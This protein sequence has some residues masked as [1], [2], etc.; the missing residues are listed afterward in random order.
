MS[1]S[2]SKIEFASQEPDEFSAIMLDDGVKPLQVEARVSTRERLRRGEMDLLAER[3]R[4]AEG[5]DSRFKLEP[6]QLLNPADPVEWKRDG[7]QEGV[8]R[9]LR[10]G[11]YSADARLDLLNR[12]LAESVDEVPSFIKQCRRLGLR[13]V[14]IN[15]GRGQYPDSPQNILKSCLV[16][17]LPKIDDVLA[18]HSTQPQHGG[19]AAMYLLLRKNEQQRIEN[20]ERHR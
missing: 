11:K 16:L 1:K 9:N 18:F 19:L 10:L 3:R 5:L 13:T 12:S 20:I 8:Y 4:Q 17:W 6:E 7:V 2:D 14:V 15:H